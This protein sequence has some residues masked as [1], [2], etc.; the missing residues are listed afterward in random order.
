MKPKALLGVPAIHAGGGGTVR[1]P[2]NCTAAGFLGGPAGNALMVDAL[3]RRTRAKVISTAVV[4]PYLPAVNDGLRSFPLGP[5][6]VTLFAP[7]VL[8][9]LSTARMHMAPEKLLPVR[10]SRLCHWRRKTTKGL[11]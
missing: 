6:E 11:R 5:S 9:A 4:T 10:P 1:R 2:K 8:N 7:Q 3:E